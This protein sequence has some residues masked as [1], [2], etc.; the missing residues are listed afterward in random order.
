MWNVTWTNR[1]HG[2]GSASRLHARLTIRAAKAITGG[3]QIARR[4][5]FGFEAI[6]CVSA[7]IQ[8]SHELTLRRKSGGADGLTTIGI[9]VAPTTR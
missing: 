1:S 2:D 5:A 9:G 6:E 4:R 8:H 7:N 3:F